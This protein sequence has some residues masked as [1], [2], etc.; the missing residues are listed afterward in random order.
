LAL[1]EVWHVRSTGLIELLVHPK[2]SP[3]AQ[4]ITGQMISMKPNLAPQV[5]ANPSFDEVT[6]WAGKQFFIDRHKCDTS[7]FWF[8]AVPKKKWLM[9]HLI[10]TDC[11]VLEKK[12][13][14]QMVVKLMVI[15]IPW[16]QIC[17]KSRN[18]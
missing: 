6:Y 10:W 15:F 5:V 3:S 16:D 12:P 7:C 18:R 14:D 17:N 8:L 11:L 13:S 9:E 1:S 2:R 4:C